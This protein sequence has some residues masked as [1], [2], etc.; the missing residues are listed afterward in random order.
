MNDSPKRNNKEK[1]KLIKN[2]K[3]KGNYNEMYR[4]S[5]VKRTE[6][7][8]IKVTIDNVLFQTKII[9]LNV[10]KILIIIFIIFTMIFLIIY[11]YK[12]TL[13]ILFIDNFKNIINDFKVLITQY[14][15]VILYWNAIKTMFILPNATIYVNLNETEEYFINLNSRVNYIYKFRIKRYKRMSELYDILLSSSLGQNQST[16]D[17]CLDHQRCIEVKNSRNFL[18]ANGLESTVILYGKEIYNYYKDFLLIKNNIKTKEDIIKNFLGERYSALSSNINHVI[19][20]IEQLFFGYFLNDEKDTV[21]DFYLKIK[22]MNIVEICYCAL[23]NLFSALFVYN[24]IT[25]I[26][27]SVEVASTRINNSII[28]LKNMKLERIN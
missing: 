5:I 4:S 2:N 20:Y 26:V 8:E 3:N 7:E 9:M 27:Y 10:I 23:L 22:I 25:R 13:S 14:N 12:L 17:F 11:I 1:T 16:F 24:Y 19:I 28:R 18:L 15:H 6:K 21:N